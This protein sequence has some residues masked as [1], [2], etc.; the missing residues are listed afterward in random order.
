M[1]GCAAVRVAAGVPDAPDKRESLSCY[2]KD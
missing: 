2:P 1:N